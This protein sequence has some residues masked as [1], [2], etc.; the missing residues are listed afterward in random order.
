MDLELK[1]CNGRGL[2][3]LKVAGPA[4]MP[5][6]WT[7]GRR[8]ARVGSATGG[9][10]E[11]SRTAAAGR[12][13]LGRNG[14]AALVVCLNCLKNQCFTQ[15]V[16]QN[17]RLDGQNRARPALSRVCALPAC[18][19][20]AGRRRRALRGGPEGTP[21]G[22]H[23][24]AWPRACRRARVRVSARMC[25]RVTRTRAFGLTAEACTPWES[26]RDPQ[27]GARLRLAEGP[28][29][30]V[31][32]GVC[33]RPGASVRELRRPSTGGRGVPPALQTPPFAINALRGRK[34]PSS[35]IGNKGGLSK[36]LLVAI[37]P[38]TKKYRAAVGI[39]KISRRFYGRGKI[40]RRGRAVGGRSCARDGG[41]GQL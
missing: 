25:A 24:Y 23:P 12:R 16:Q 40:L 9:A 4:K 11:R 15:F 36:H 8:L 34:H 27:R 10:S 20:S 30:G 19:P 31:C 28:S 17:R 32:V 41:D 3:R 7:A 6:A 22:A 21:D 35:I 26:R 39:G 13:K 5:A 37:T 29:A 2:A 1:K 18:M 33:A 14:R 38:S